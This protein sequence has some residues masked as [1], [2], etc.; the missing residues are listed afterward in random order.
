LSYRNVKLRREAVIPIGPALT[1][2]L[3]LQEEYLNYMHGHD[4]TEFLLHLPARSAAGQLARRRTSP[5]SR[6]GPPADQELRA[7]G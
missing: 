6:V 4:G 2:Q 5:V 3:R 7:Q 1:D